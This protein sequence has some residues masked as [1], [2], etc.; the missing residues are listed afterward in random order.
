MTPSKPYFVRAVYDWVIDNDCTPFVAVNANMP[1][2]DVPREH[3]EDGQITL[4]LAPSAITHLHMDNHLIQFSA[5]FGGV[6]RNISVPIGAVL[7]IYAKENGQ[8][9]AFPDADEYQEDNG[10]HADTDP[11]PEPQ[12]PRPSGRPSL[13]VVK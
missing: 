11:N 13:K 10:L 3:V 2:V 12:P 1:S 9:M 5:R 6:A 4:N 7:G 8:G